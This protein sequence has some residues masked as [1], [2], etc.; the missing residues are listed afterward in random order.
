MKLLTAI[1][2]SLAIGFILGHTARADKAIYQAG[3]Q[4]CQEQF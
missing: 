1:L 2:V 4:A 3:F